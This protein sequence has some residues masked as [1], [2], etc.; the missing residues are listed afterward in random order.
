MKKK[1]L[2]LPGI[3]CMAVSLC[4]HTGRVDA[5]AAA[6]DSSASAPAQNTSQ[7]PEDTANQQTD[8]PEVPESY[9]WE[10]QS[11]KIS[12]WPEG[13]K[14]VAETAI[15]MDVIPGKSFMPKGSTKS[16]PLPALQRL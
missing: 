1:R 5:M 11:N 6:A 9:N 7:N 2:L 12:G 15:L 13:P 16:A 10:I 3:L 8:T 14:V 4:I